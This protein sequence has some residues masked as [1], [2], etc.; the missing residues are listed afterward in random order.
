MSK[1]PAFQILVVDIQE[2]FQPHIANYQHIVET[3]HKLLSA[4]ELLA[5]PA[6][7][8]EQYPKGLGH[9]DSSLL[10]FNLDRYEKTTFSAVRGS[11][12]NPTINM[13]PNV[14]KVVIGLESH[15]CVYQTVCDLLT[16]AQPVIVIADAVGSRNTQHKQWAI[17]QLRYQGAVI[18]SLETLL[19]DILKDAKHPQFKAVS[20]LIR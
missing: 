15:V 18:M 1:Q 9:T 10:Q 16:L 7:V 12:P 11:E 13:D 8:F 4:A 2:S 17:E 5:I 19:F 20:K 6:V 14:T 3:A